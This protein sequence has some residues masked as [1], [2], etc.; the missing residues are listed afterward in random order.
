MNGAKLAD[1]PALPPVVPPAA[2]VAPVVSLLSPG[3]AAIATAGTR[4]LASV[5]AAL[6]AEVGV[7]SAAISDRSALALRYEMAR[8]RK[9]TEAALLLA[10][11]H[12]AKDLE[13]ERL[14][15]SLRGKV[16]IPAGERG[17]V[18]FDNFTPTTKAPALAG[19]Q[20]VERY[21]HAGLLPKVGLKALRGD[22][23]F[24]RAGVISINT[25]TTA[26]TSA[27]EITHATEQQAPSVLAKALAF[28]KQR[29][30]NEPLKT[31][32]SLTGIKKYGAGEYAWEDDF[33]KR[34]GSHYMGKTY[35]ARATEILTMG[36]ERL[37]ADPM[38]FYLADRTYFE[39]VVSTLQ[40]L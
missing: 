37:H 3:A 24:H 25:R 2:V 19:A 21:T 20:I 16:E 29:A 15:E 10:S 32:R 4:T 18:Q 14:I 8:A 34:G 1:P 31:L 28:L 9:D 39:F 30:G 22:R 38:E 13:V 11:E 27:H 5:T 12:A 17:K 40:N 6:D 7:Y 36:I 33:K 23:A 26:S 35:G